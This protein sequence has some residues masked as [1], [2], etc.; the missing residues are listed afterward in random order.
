M[1]MESRSSVCMMPRTEAVLF[2]AKDTNLGNLS[3]S[4]SPAQVSS[5]K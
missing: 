1:K 3:D 2:F 4:I 5:Q